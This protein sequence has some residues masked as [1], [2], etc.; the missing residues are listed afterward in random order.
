MIQFTSQCQ[1]R[2]EKWRNIDKHDKI[3]DNKNTA[4]LIEQQTD[5]LGFIILTRK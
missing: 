1:R 4:D 3:N 5:Y 2:Q